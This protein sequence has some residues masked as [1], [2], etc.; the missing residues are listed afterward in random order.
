[1]LYVLAPK[2]TIF[3]QDPKEIIKVKL[4]HSGG[5]LIQRVRALI[6]HKRG[7]PCSLF[8][9]LSLP[10]PSLPSSLSPHPTMWGHSKEVAVRK[11]GG[12]P[13]PEPDQ[14]RP[15]SWTF[16]P[17]ELGENCCGRPPVCS[18]RPKQHPPH[19]GFRDWVA[20]GRHLD[21]KHPQIPSRDLG[22]RWGRFN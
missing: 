12:G 4:G 5:V 17:P 7:L 19:K 3:R 13:S 6:R 16:Q 1:M 21:Q 11:L 15:W 2:L 10:P 20:K 18:S 22:H 14:A 8:L 9:S